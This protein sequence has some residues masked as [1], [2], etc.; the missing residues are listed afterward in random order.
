[1]KNDWVWRK[2]LERFI[3]ILN[4]SVNIT[5]VLFF[6]LVSIFEKLHTQFKSLLIEELQIPE[7]Q[8]NM[9]YASIYF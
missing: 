9:A 2:I 7:P 3:T 6:Q 8:F 5:G 1:M 4:I